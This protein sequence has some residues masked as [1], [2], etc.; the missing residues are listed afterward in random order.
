MFTQSKTFNLITSRLAGK[1]AHDGA[2]TFDAA[3][4]IEI[5]LQQLHD[6]L[7]ELKAEAPDGQ[8][9]DIEDVARILKVSVRTVETLVAEG[10]LIPLRIRSMR[11]FTREGIDAYLRSAA[12]PR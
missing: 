5:S 9:L 11:R 8:L 10:K 1:P 4:E 6:S 12:K 7:E 2:A 3:N